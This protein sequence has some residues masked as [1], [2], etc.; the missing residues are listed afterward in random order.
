MII[1]SQKDSS[2]MANPPLGKAKV[3]L[4]IDN[5][6]KI[7]KSDGS[8]ISLEE[9]AL[10]IGDAESVSYITNDTN[11]WLWAVGVPVN[12]EQA[13]DYLAEEVREIGQTVD[14]L[15]PDKADILTDLIVSATITYQGKLPSGLPSPWYTEAIAGDVLAT[16][17]YDNVF[18]LNAVDFRSGKANT[19][20]T[21]GQ[22]S[23]VIDGI[24]GD[25]HDMT[26]GT[27]T[28]GI[29]TILD[30]S[31]FLNFWVASDAELN[32]IQASEGLVQYQ[33]EH[34]EAGLSNPIKMYYD[35]N[36]TA[37]AFALPLTIAEDVKVSKYLSGIEYY[38]FGS[39]FLI[40][41][42][43]DHLF[44]KVYK[45][46]GVTKV[47]CIGLNDLNI[48]PVTPPS[49]TDVFTI[50]NKSITLNKADECDLN[51]QI[52]VVAAKPN[53]NSAA[54]SIVNIFAVLGKAISTY[55]VVSTVTSELFQ[56]EDKRLN[57]GTS[58]SFDSTII[59]PNGEAQVKCGILE[60]GDIDYPAKSGDQQFDRLFNKTTANSGII[61]FGSFNTANISSYGTGQ[62]NVMLQLENDGKWF[63]LGKAFGDNAGNGDTIAT[64]RGAR[65]SLSGNS[66]N[67]SFGTFT[68][69]NNNHQYRMVIIFK[70]NVHIID[71]VLTS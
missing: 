10:G 22:L 56:D 8:L 3:F 24:S 39:T 34:T 23:A 54:S 48:D 18:K 71:A 27:G 32:I 4:D 15:A 45:P 57:A 12:V 69:A 46:I 31:P 14:L 5:D 29:V 59:L 43:I 70:N 51:P 68:T 60:Y 28:T 33:M 49:W 42:S 47:S 55:G 6:F 66:L 52:S 44:K 16:V 62:V 61:N 2:L 17:I 35:D 64:A 1:V 13:L 53:N 65:V 30:I 9:A 26:T 20:A 7:L 63:D 21:Y 19:P 37:P 41:Y 36:L 40:G 50:S 67:F 58:V 11:F 38:G 25:T